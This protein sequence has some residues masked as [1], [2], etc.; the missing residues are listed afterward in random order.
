MDF[1][2]VFGEKVT[3]YVIVDVVLGEI[4]DHLP[5]LVQLLLGV[6]SHHLL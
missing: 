3:H 2:E 1:F 4:L 6:Q 5:A